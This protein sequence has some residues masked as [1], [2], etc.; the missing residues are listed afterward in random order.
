MTSIS[1]VQQIVAS[2]RSGM[3]GRVPAKS[4]KK[5]R[6]DTSG[7]EQSGMSRL[8][9]ERIKAL[10]PDDPKRGRKAFRIFLE[11]VLLSELGEGLINEPQFY[12]MVDQ[13]Q[14]TMERDPRILAAIEQAVTALLN[15]KPAA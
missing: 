3:A 4:E 7:Q 6:T 11:S 14:D 9:A 5:S 8:I 2:I 15:E 1:S 13:I 10:D 12:Q